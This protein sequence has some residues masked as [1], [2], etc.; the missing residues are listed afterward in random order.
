[1]P[2]IIYSHCNLRRTKVSTNVIQHYDLTEYKIL[3][4][5][6][7]LE[8]FDSKLILSVP[9]LFRVPSTCGRI[10]KSV[11]IDGYPPPITDKLRGW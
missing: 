7:L 4:T 8:V 6:S 1:M 5:T 9:R 3:N 10:A 2:K 11:S